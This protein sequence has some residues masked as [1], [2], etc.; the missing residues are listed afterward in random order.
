MQCSQHRRIRL[1]STP[2][3]LLAEVGRS[4]LITTSWQAVP[5]VPALHV[6]LDPFPV[7]PPIAYYSGIDYASTIAGNRVLGQ[8]T[9]KHSIHIPHSQPCT[10]KR[11]LRVKRSHFCLQLESVPTCVPS[12]AP[13]SSSLLNACTMHHAHLTNHCCVVTSRV[14]ARQ[15]FLVC[16]IHCKTACPV[17]FRAA[18]SPRPGAPRTSRACPAQIPT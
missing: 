3:F 8:T 12:L 15:H 17:D 7:P 10:C 14:A 4:E 16:F 2:P 13:T 18:L 6:R 1:L 9:N 5:F 11:R